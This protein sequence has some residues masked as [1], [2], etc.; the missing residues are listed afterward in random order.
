MARLI[1]I[2]NIACSECGKVGVICKGICQACYSKKMRKTPKGMAYQKEYYATKGRDANRRYRDKHRKPKKE[3]I[4]TFCECGR[5][6]TVKG[7]CIACYQKN[8]QKNH[9][10]KTYNR[11]PRIKKPVT[12][13]EG[14]RR[15]IIKGRSDRLFAMVLHEVE[16][17]STISL[18]CIKL[19]VDSGTL[20]RYISEEQK[21]ILQEAKYV[22]ANYIIHEDFIDNRPAD[23]TL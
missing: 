7:M 11:Q 13:K 3:R 2:L 8:Y 14:Q 15:R 16:S 17:G 4:T 23:P 9:P 5:V 18:A 12:G 1:Q 21:L 22:Y 6:A 20:Y 10:Q 19:K